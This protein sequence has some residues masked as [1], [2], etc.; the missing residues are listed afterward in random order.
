MFKKGG[1]DAL[2]LPVYMAS[3]GN[4]ALV[5]NEAMRAAHALMPDAIYETIPGA[6]HE[7]IEEQDQYR[8]RL[9]EGFYALLERAG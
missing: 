9:M 1:F 3:A 8:D 6:L 4:E 5:S 7:L 2:S